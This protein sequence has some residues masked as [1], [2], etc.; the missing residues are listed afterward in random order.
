V[1]I[2]WIRDRGVTVRVD[3]GGVRAVRMSGLLFSIVG[4]GVLAAIDVAGPSSMV[5]VPVTM[6][7]N[8]RYIGVWESRVRQGRVDRGVAIWVGGN[9]GIVRTVSLSFRLFIVRIG[10]V[11]MSDRVVGIVVRSVDWTIAVVVRGVHG[12]MATFD[13]GRAGRS[14]HVNLLMPGSLGS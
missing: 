12:S 7:R 2:R 8:S 1:P 9:R 6:S 10:R 5:H 3:R 14:A 13:Y 4:I 11:G